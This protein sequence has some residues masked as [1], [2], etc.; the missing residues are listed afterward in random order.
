MPWKTLPRAPHSASRC[1]TRSQRL[2]RRR[3]APPASGSA[4]GDARQQRARPPG[5]RKPAR[6]PIGGRDAARPPRP[7]TGAHRRQRPLHAARA[8]RRR[9]RAASAFSSSGS[10]VGVARLE[11][12]VGGLAALAGVGAEQGQP[13]ERAAQHAAQPVVDGDWH[14]SPRRSASPIS[15]PVSGSFSDQRAAAL[16]GD[17]HPAVVCAGRASW[18]ASIASSTGTARGSPVAAIA[19]PRRSWRRSPC[20]RAA[21]PAPRRSVARRPAQRSAARR[22]DLRR[23]GRASAAERRGRQRARSRAAGRMTLESPWR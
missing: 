21:G 14:R 19:R 3:R 2:R 23:T 20:R 16:L 10:S 12:R 4:A 17:H 1:S 11:H 22:S 8:R 18:P 7:A 5:R 9:S 6:S 15:A 13:A